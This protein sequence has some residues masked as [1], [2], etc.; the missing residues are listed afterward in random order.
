MAFMLSSALSAAEVHTIH[1]Q[2][3]WTISTPQVQLAIMQR[4]AHMAVPVRHEF[5]KRGKL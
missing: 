2:P 1:A 5:L 4:G 3:S